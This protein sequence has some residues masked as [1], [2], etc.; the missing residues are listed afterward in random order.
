MTE[1]RKKISLLTNLDNILGHNYVN[2]HV[3]TYNFD[4]MIM[5]CVNDVSYDVSDKHVKI[6]LYLDEM[7]IEMKNNF[8]CQTISLPYAI[9]EKVYILLE[10]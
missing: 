2:N 6:V 3:F 4:S 10:D 1:S 9:I 5:L 7:I 8:D